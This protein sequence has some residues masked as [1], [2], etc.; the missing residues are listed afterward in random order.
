[1]NHMTNNCEIV[2]NVACGVEFKYCRT[3]KVE[4][5][6]C[7]GNKTP[8][9]FESLPYTLHTYQVELVRDN[10]VTKRPEFKVG[11]KVRI[12]DCGVHKNLLHCVGTVTQVNLPGTVYY[13]DGRTNSETEYDLDSTPG[14]I[15]AGRCLEHV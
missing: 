4:P 15:W 7:P 14:N 9:D 10:E 6:D 5:K 13:M 2:D 1:M 3:H 8:E 11:D 12:V